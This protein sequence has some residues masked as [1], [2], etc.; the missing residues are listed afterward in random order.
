M[1]DRYDPTGQ[2]RLVPTVTVGAA[3]GTGPPAPTVDFDSNDERGTVRFGSG[4]TPGAGVV[5]TVNFVLP[6]DP[7]RLPK[8]MLQEVTAATAGIDLAVTSVTSTGFA[9]STNTRNLAASQ[10]AGTYAVYYSVID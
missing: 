9:V 5:F 3:D 10:A 4:T 7:N 6:R 1:P 8:V 2:D